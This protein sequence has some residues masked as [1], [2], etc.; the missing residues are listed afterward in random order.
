MNPANAP[1]LGQVIAD[2]RR[3]EEKQIHTENQTMIQQI[4]T[5]ASD[6]KTTPVQKL[7]LYCN[8]VAHFFQSQ[9]NWFFANE[10]RHKS[11]EDHLLQ[12]WK[13]ITSDRTLFPDP[14][15]VQETRDKKLKWISQKAVWNRPIPSATDLVA[16]TKWEVLTHRLLP[17]PIADATF[18]AASAAASAAAVI[19]PTTIASATIVSNASTLTLPSSLS[20][21]I[22]GSVAPPER[23]GQSMGNLH[24]ILFPPKSGSA[25]EAQDFH[26]AADWQVCPDEMKDIYRGLGGP[27]G[28]IRYVGANVKP[29]VARFHPSIETDYTVP[30]VL[31]NSGAFIHIAYTPHNDT[32]TKWTRSVLYDM[33]DSPFL[34]LSKAVAGQPRTTT[35]GE[36]ITEESEFTGHVYSCV[37]GD[38]SD[39]TSLILR[40]E[41]QQVQSKEFKKPLSFYGGSRSWAVLRMALFVPH[42]MI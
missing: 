24:V 22:V 27:P 21:A 23:K 17:L 8:V 42:S 40:M 41:V 36:I 14:T 29:S 6:M 34:E 12:A 18:A 15:L 37:F 4:D 5:I 13:K 35:L 26:V 38:S 30:I 32:K 31:H 20:M 28:S 33:N 7:E 16:K 19:A 1:S 2:L 10:G 3:S 9:L 39:P 11:A 25:L